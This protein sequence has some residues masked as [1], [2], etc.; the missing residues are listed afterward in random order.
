MR[1]VFSLP[2]I[3]SGLSTPRRAAI[4][5]QQSPPLVADWS[6]LMQMRTPNAPSLIG[7]KR[8]CPDCSEWSHSDLWLV[9]ED[10]DEGYSCAALIRQE[11]PQ[12]YWLKYNYRN[13]FVRVGSRGRDIVQAGSLVWEAGSS[14]QAFP[15]GVICMRGPLVE[16]ADRFC[17]LNLRP[18]KPLGALFS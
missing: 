14:V 18:D 9:N 2:E 17:F 5:K 8:Y 7:P 12:S 10:V 3:G 6:I 13:S 15:W 11:T 4:C 16:M 1:E